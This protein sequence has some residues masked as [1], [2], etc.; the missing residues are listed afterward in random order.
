MK[1][2]ITPLFLL[3]FGLS[4][5][6]PLSPAAPQQQKDKKAK[7][8][9]QQEEKIFIPKDVKTALQAGLA[10][11]QGRQDIPYTIFRH[12]YLP[13]REN[14]HIVFFLKIKNADLGFVPVGTVTQQPQK[15][16]EEKEKEE[17][18]QVPEAQPPSELQANFNIFLQF[19]LIGEGGTSQILKEVFV[20]ANFRVESP[21]YDPEKEETYMI[22]YP[23]PPGKYILA[24]AVTSLDLQ[25]IGTSYFEFSLSD[26]TSFTDTLGATPVFFI[27]SIEQ[28]G[29]PEMKTSVHKDFFTYSILKIM[30]NIDN[31]FA[32]GENLDIFYF[33]FGAQPNE[34][35]QYEIET[36][37]EVKKDE[38]MAIRWQP[39]TYNAPLVSQPLP[40][41]Q[42]VVTTLESGEQKQ[43]Q[44]DLAAGVYTL[45]IK[46]TDKLSG[47]TLTE[48][49][50]FEVK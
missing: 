7:P 3:V 6:V 27:K 24:M 48:E 33:I 15:A 49:V 21:V 39:Q 34:Q 47:K 28:M 37:Y 12:L 31:V 46:I 43:E 38:D 41:K 18:A 23:L 42:T 29:S 9:A 45:V 5:L 17:E 10:S 22:G 30:P 8:E 35:Q 50:N 14:F 40:L 32:V 16:K 4:V 2:L 1:K 44:R 25:K 13:A 36:N 20:P 19:N 26:M 11:R